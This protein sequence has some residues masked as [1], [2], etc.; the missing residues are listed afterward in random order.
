HTP[1]RR[2]VQDVLAAIRN[3][4]PLASCGNNTQ[5]TAEHGLRS[6]HAFA[7]LFSDDPAAVSRTLEIAERCAFSLKEIR[8]RYPS[9]Y[10]PDGTTSVQWLRRLSFAGARERYPHGVPAAVASQLEKELE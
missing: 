6:P 7:K 3:G 10:L 9:E 5:P 1:A 4:L 8:Y 2:A